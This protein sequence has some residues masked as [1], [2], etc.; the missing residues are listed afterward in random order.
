A[1]RISK[2]VQ[3]TA[4]VLAFSVMNVYVMAAPLRTP[5]D[6][7]TTDASA[8]QPKSEKVVVETAGDRTVAE[9]Q[10][11]PTQAAAEKMALRAGS[12]SALTRIF[13]KK[14]VE[15]RAAAGTSFLNTKTNFAETFKTPA[16][17]TA[18]PQ[19]SGQ[20]SSDDSDHS[21]RRSTWIAVGIIAAVLTIAV[22]GLRH[23]RSHP[24]AANG[25]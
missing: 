23:D 7:R 16:K 15:A 2:M 10:Q 13:S 14:D 19:S 1:S 9:D 3:L 6:P 5:T 20:T 8:N 21:G 24:D 12:K 11:L 18:A 22:I 25:L 4:L 17:N